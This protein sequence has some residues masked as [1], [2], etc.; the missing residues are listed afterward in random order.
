MG[1]PLPSSYIKNL[2]YLIE[3]DQEWLENTKKL[4]SE[5]ETLHTACY[6]ELF[7]KSDVF[8]F[9]PKMPFA[10]PLEY[11]QPIHVDGKRL[12]PRFSH[13]STTALYFSETGLCLI[14]KYIAS[15]EG[16]GFFSHYLHFRLENP[17]I[18]V[19]EKSISVS[20]SGNVQLEN[21]IVG[22]SEDKNVSFTFLH[23]NIENRI[24]KKED[25]LISK[26][27]EEVYRR[28]GET[29]VSANIEGFTVSVRHFTPHP[30]AFQACREFGYSSYIDMENDIVNLFRKLFIKFKETQ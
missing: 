16:L 6:G 19:L 12:S 8:L 20:F 28:H 17:Q 10:R 29:F 11:F 13:G 24:V 2:D 1:G 27:M 26:K 7:S 4:S 23:E 22:G 18:R 21:L 14:S 15:R 25:A 3:R 30:F 5:M 9:E